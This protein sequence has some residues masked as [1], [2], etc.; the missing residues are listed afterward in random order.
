MVLKSI[1]IIIIIRVLFKNVS[2]SYLILRVG[3]I[4]GD[5]RTTLGLALT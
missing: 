4:Q 1:I 3:I 2:F 5:E